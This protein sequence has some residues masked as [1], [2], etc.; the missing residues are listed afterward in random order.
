MGFKQLVLASNNAGKIKEFT[1]FFAKYQV[2]IIPQFELGIAEVEEPFHTFVE[3]ALHKARH[4]TRYTSLPVLADDSGLCVKSLN[5]APGVYSARFAGEP[6]NPKANITKL[7]NELA[8]HSNRSS[9]Y[10]CILVLMRNHDDP[11]PLISEGV[12]PGEITLSPMGNNGFGYDEYFHIPKYNLTMAQLDLDIKNQI[13]HRAQAL[14]SLINKL[15]L[16]IAK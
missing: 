14:N 10:Y 1:Q 13:S 4:C 6:R 7:L 9:Y 5:N 16:A 15:S 3:N 2:Q 8:T 11:Q 12:L